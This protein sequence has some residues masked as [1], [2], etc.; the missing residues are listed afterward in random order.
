MKHYVKTREG[1]TLGY[2]IDLDDRAVEIAVGFR[3]I[4][5]FAA[6][7]LASANADDPHSPRISVN[8]ELAAVFISF[9][10]PR[11]RMCTR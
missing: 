3:I 5:R 2:F 8:N 1:V 9:Y 11:R 10:L 7:A 6:R 4:L